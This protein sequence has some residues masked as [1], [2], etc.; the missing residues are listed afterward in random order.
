MSLLSHLQEGR[1]FF[2]SKNGLTSAQKAHLFFRN[3]ETQPVPAQVLPGQGRAAGAR[4]CEHRKSGGHAL[5]PPHLPFT[6]ELLCQDAIVAGLIPGS[7]LPNAGT[8]FIPMSNLCGRITLQ[9]ASANTCRCH[10]VQ[11]TGLCPRPEN[12]PWIPDPTHP[13]PPLEGAYLHV[14]LGIKSTLT[15]SRQSQGRR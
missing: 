2:F 7:S 4:E 5:Q 15:A 9:W 12:V 3:Q 14:C 8:L 6:T 10:V 11:R 1:S 13:H